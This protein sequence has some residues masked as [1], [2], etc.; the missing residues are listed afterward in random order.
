MKQLRPAFSV[1]KG[2]SEIKVNRTLKGVKRGEPFNVET[3]ANEVIV[4]PLSFD[5]FPTSFIASGKSHAEGG[6]KMNL[7]DNSFVFSD[8]KSMKLKDEELQKDFNKREKKTGYTYADIAKQYNINKYRKVLADP[9]SDKMQRETAEDMIKNYNEKL[10]KLSLVQESSKG[11][12]QGIPFVAIPYLEMVGVNAADYVNGDN[13]G[14]PEVPLTSEEDIPM[15]AKGGQ[16]KVRIKKVP[17]YQKGGPK[18]SEDQ[19]FAY[20]P[21]FYAEFA[22]K[23]GVND[24]SAI[25]PNTLSDQRGMVQNL[26]PELS[27][28]IY[29]R[30]NWADPALF[31][32]FK[33]RNAWYFRQNPNFDPTKT[34]DV[35]K[36]QQAYNTRAESMGL[37]PY[38]SKDKGS[39]YSL[40]SKFGEVT[41][42]VPNLDT[43]ANTQQSPSLP[44]PVVN[45]TMPELQKPV[46]TTTTV[47]EDVPYWTEDIVNMAGAFGDMQRIKKYMPWQ[48]G[49]DTT[50]PDPTYFDPTREL[51]ANAEQS[52]IAANALGAFA[53]PQELSARLSS[54]QGQGLS[55]AANILGKYNNLNVGISNQTEAYRANI[56]NDASLKRADQATNLYDKTVLTNQA[57]DNARTQARQNLRQSFITAHSN[58]GRTQALN[59]MNK[60]YKVNP[61]NGFVEF[62]GVPGTLNTGSQTQSALDLYN[63]ILAQ[64]GMDSKTAAD[65]FKS[66]Y[67]GK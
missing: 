10:G 19:E 3:E 31:E 55:N 25:L 24:I 26:Q 2:E 20:N 13:A 33:S 32:D 4:S 46:M 8:D 5:G 28:N 59:S 6:I 43:K 64:P 58:R 66:I 11:Y 44:Q 27:N 35:G 9:N 34:E 18:K 60:Q 48:A 63:E 37:K 38:F 7:P 15:Q 21:E 29:G 45:Q 57:F 14:Q 47:K 39:K 50:L 61:I 67:L 12:P 52:N 54:V 30:K 56:S 16:I 42:S 41:Y 65:V 22:K 53:G 51:A 49:F 1:P 23:L 40:D 17:S 62:S 36:F